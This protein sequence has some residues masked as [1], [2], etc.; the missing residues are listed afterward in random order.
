MTVGAPATR[1]AATA[2]TAAPAR[3]RLGLP[4]LLVL[5][6]LLGVAWRIWLARYSAMP[7]GHTD[8]DSYLNTAR[9]L[10][11][12]PGGFSSENETLR[13]IGYPLLIAPAF[14]LDRDFVDT[15]LLVRL[16]NAALN[17]A[18]FPLA[19]LLGRRLLGLSRWAAL[20][21]AGV[22]A[23]LPA[24]LL[25][26]GM[27]MTDAVLAPL[28]LAWLLAAHRLVER[29]GPAA[30]AVGGALAGAFHLVHSRGVV[31]VAGYAVLLLALVVRRRLGPAGLL[32]ATLPVLAAAVGNEAGVRLLGDTVQLLG[33]PPDGGSLRSVLSGRGL[34]QVLASAGTQLWYLM[35]VTFGLA[36]LAGA[37]AVTRLRRRG[38]DAARWT[39]GLALLTT[40]G[41]AVGAEVVLAAVPGRV[42]DAIYARY[43]QTLAPF[44]LLVGVGVLFG[45]AYRPLL[46]RAAVTVVLLA[47][48]GWLVQ[49]RLA[50]AVAGGA[51]LRYGMFS[52][53]DLMVLTGG[54]PQMR[55]L[56][57]A[58]VGAGGCLLLV[59]AAR[60]ARLRAIMLAVL[61]VVNV[62]TTQVIMHRLVRPLGVAG[63]PAPSVTE[64]GIRPGERVAAAKA[65][66]YAIRHNLSHQ[67]TWTEVPWFTDR[68]PAAAGVVFARW[69]PGR[70]GDWDG[71]RYGFDRIGG[72][73]AQEWAAWRRR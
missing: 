49:L 61:L 72:N 36:G 24:A 68:P 23:T 50:D 10:A 27:A 7:I 73:A 48:G 17:A 60:R 4:L 13:R 33:N 65:V 59:L 55:P 66:P 8:E 44:W 11:G 12:G 35:V 41:V 6:W 37:D 20:A 40:V 54:W 22:A 62:A 28:L 30:A 29:P 57:G 58:A 46:R 5:G 15:Y 16:I 1:P 53:P 14:L 25:Y 71:T 34:S 39:L 3:R 67:V 38:D 45:V 18:L 2:G 43:V 64:L 42:P 63:T 21:A 69:V 26:A 19:F 31:V 9:A 70:P 32:A 56:V 51:P 47:A 52:A